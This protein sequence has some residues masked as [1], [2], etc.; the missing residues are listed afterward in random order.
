MIDRKV[1]QVHP[2]LRPGAEDSGRHFSEFEERANIVLLGDPSAGKSHL[3][4]ESA[5]TGGGRYLN[6]RTFLNVPS[7]SPAVVLFIDALDERR[8]GRGDRGTVDAMVQKL[9]IVAPSKVRISCRYVDWLGES[10]LAA[11]EPYFE[12]S[13]DTVVLGLERLSPEEQRGVLST[14]GMSAAE[15]ETFIQ[16][17]GNRG[18][19]EFL[20]NPRN[21]IMLVDAVKTGSW[22][23]TRSELFALSTRLLLSEPNGEHARAERGVYTTNELQS[24]AGGACAARLISDV[25]GI[26]LPGRASGPTKLQDAR[27]SRCSESA[28]GVGTTRLRS[29]PSPGKRRL[30]AP[31][32]RRVPRSAVAGGQNSERRASRTGARVDGRGWSSGSRT[33]RPARVAR[34]VFT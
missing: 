26:S 30:R 13:G 17:T 25:S 20:E 3:F 11:F 9:F 16:E 31:Y 14:Q 19:A 28:S 32:D 24:A 33:P 10:D 27:P 8:S 5:A 15:I 6:V 2:T 22:P 29:W 12:Q 18:L 4:R 21:L 34:P 1:R 7:F 23:G